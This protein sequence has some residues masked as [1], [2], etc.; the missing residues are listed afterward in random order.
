[1]IEQW[2]NTA[3]GDAA[4]RLL[5]ITSLAAGEGG[6]SG[7]GMKSKVQQLIWLLR[8]AMYPNIYSAALVRPQ[9]LR[10]FVTGKLQEAAEL[11]SE[12]CACVMTATCTE[13]IK[14]TADCDA[15]AEKGL[16]DARS[17]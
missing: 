14:G 7:Y 13:Q 6:F 10:A 1:M 2:L 4:G 12:M 5:D 11:L 3:A 9:A 15:C 17:R 16:R 8:C